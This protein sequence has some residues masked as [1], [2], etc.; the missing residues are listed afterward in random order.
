MKGTQRLDIPT[1]Y[2]VASR[3]VATEA[4]DLASHYKVCHFRTGGLHSQDRNKPVWDGERG[5]CH[6]SNWPKLDQLAKV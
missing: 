4:P 1:V 2:S 3:A 6:C 5:V